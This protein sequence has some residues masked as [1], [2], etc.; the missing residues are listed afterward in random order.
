VWLELDGGQWMIV[1]PHCTVSILDLAF[2][3]GGPVSIQRGDR[4]AAVITIGARAGRPAQTFQPYQCHHLIW[5][6]TQVW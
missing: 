1:P 3:L 2:A 5:G 4:Q 6:E